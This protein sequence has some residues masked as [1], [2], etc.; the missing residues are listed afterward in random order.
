MN[1]LLKVLLYELKSSFRSKWIII[2]ALFFFLIAQGLFFFSGDD[3][4]VLL[5]LFNII[6]LIIPVIALFYGL[7]FFYSEKNFI[8]MM[9]VRD[10]NPLRLFAGVYL[11]LTVTISAGVL[12]GLAAALLINSG[13]TGFEPA[14]FLSLIANCLFL[15][16]IFSAIASFIA[17]RFNDRTRGFIAAVAVWLFTFVIYDGL[18]LALSYILR[19][20]PAD[21]IM[22]AVVLLNPVD[23]SR[24]LL[25]LQ[26]DVAML[27]GYSAAV[28][29]HT[30]GSGLSMAVLFFLLLSWVAVPYS[31]TLRSFKRRDFSA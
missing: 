5:S 15:I 12:A 23:I 31:I 10:I 20:Y 3:S 29:Q 11:G 24:I 26:F 2:C 13:K 21:N 16:F 9:L 22:L 4:K 18:I 19:D 1:T 7:T 8:E 30:L 17:F 14:I 6:L 25:L 27:M 28:Y